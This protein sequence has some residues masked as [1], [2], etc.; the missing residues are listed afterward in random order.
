M[1]KNLNPSK[2]IVKSPQS[3]WN[4]YLSALLDRKIAEKVEQR[5]RVFELWF[6]RK[7][8]VLHRLH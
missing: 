1:Q 5:G 6:F 8:D 3:G 4:I 7:R 2:S